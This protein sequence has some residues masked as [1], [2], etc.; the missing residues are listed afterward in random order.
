MRSLSSYL[1]EQA[2]LAHDGRIPA[3]VKERIRQVES[4]ERQQLADMGV[5]EAAFVSLQTAMIECHEFHAVYRND[6]AALMEYL[7]S[8]RWL[9]NNCGKLLAALQAQVPH[10]DAR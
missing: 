7:E 6:P 3:E 9:G 5:A 1:R 4:I 2:E 10:E 8:V